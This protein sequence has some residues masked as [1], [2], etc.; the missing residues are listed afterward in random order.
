MKRL[1]TILL[2]SLAAISTT[3]VGLSR[4][5]IPRGFW[6]EKRVLIILAIAYLGIHAF[7][8]PIVKDV[9][10]RM[11]SRSVRRREDITELLI[12]ALSNIADQT[13]LDWRQLGVHV[14]LVKTKWRWPFRKAWWPLRNPREQVQYQVSRFKIARHP[15]S[16]G[17]RWTKGK[18]AIGDC[19]EKQVPISANLYRD[20]APYAKLTAQEWDGLDRDVR[21]GLSFDEFRRVKDYGGAIVV[22]PI[23][24]AD[25]TTKYIGCVSADSPGDSLQRLDNPSVFEVL[26]GVAK[27]TATLLSRR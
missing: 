19:W 3:I 9:K 17:I 11:T 13:G 15:P 14:F 7:A 8:Q 25:D 22:T 20:F 2:S 16:S 12:G 10:E 18:G 24:K 26:Q 6:G 27:T 4:V 1:T 23:K 21:Y 5:D